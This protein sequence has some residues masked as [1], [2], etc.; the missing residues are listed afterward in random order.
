MVGRDTAAEGLEQVFPVLPARN[1]DLLQGPCFPRCQL[2]TLAVHHDFEAPGIETDF[3]AEAVTGGKTEQEHPVLRVEHEQVIDGE[4]AG[5]LRQLV[6][7]AIGQVSDAPAGRQAAP[8]LRE[9]VVPLAVEGR[10]RRVGHIR[11]ERSHLSD[12]HRLRSLADEGQAAGRARPVAQQAHVGNHR[13]I[14]SAHG[15]ADILQRVSVQH[16][17]G[18]P[19]VAYSLR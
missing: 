15:V 3:P 9:H 13:A 11:N 2:E 8:V 10:V 14:G 12:A 6:V 17:A 16:V 1:K 7:A 19:G 5:L 4:E 18:I